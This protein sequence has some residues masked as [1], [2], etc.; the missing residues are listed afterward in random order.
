MAK[1]KYNN[2]I[3]LDIKGY[4]GKYQ[5][6]NLGRVKSLNYNKT[7]K[8][9]LLKPKINNT[10][11]PYVILCKDRVKKTLKIHRLVAETFIPNPNNYPCVNHIDENKFNNTSNNLEWCTIKYNNNYGKRKENISLKNS[12][13]IYQFDL[14][15]KFIKEW[16]GATQVEKKLG[17]KHQNISNCCAKKNKSAGGFI[18]SYTKKININEYKQKL[19]KPILQYNLNGN[20]I[21]EWESARQIQK[22][23]G[24]FN[25]NICNCCNGKIKKSN[26]YIW[27]YKEI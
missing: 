11:Y 18:W 12:K 8:E 21:R 1:I 25:S 23:L 19:K 13:K 14:Q 22:E 27:K 24:F 3:W 20:F 5:V 6:S 10:K 9:K 4:D 2:E 17:I 15:G 26:N 7:K 16:V